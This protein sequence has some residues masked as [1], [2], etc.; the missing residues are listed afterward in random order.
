M[1]ITIFK[2]VVEHQTINISLLQFQVLNVKMW[3]L[4][5][6]QLYTGQVQLALNVAG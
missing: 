4:K 1:Y 5:V 3:K 2:M 6:P